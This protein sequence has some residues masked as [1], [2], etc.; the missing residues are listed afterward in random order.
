MSEK[1]TRQTGEPT[2]LAS[3]RRLLNITQADLAHTCGISRQ[4][5]SMLETGRVQPNVQVALKL[6]STL[7]TTVEALFA[8]AEDAPVELEVVCARENMPTGTRVNVAKV[9]GTWVAHPSDTPDSIGG[10]FNTADGVIVRA[11]A[12]PIA[13]CD[14]PMRELEGNIVFAGCD[15]AMHLLCDAKLDAPGHST[16]INCGSGQALQYL[17]EGLVH[18]AGLH[19]GFDDGDENLRTIKRVLPGA[20]LFVMRFSSWEQGWLLSSRVPEN[21]NGVGDMIAH[22]LRIANREPGA[23]VRRW[24]DEELARQGVDPKNVQGY[25]TCHFSHTEAVESMQADRADLM[26]GPCV[27]ASVFGL[28]FIPI[29]RVAFDLVFNKNLFDHQRMDACLKW[30]ASKRFHQELS[31]LPG[32]YVQ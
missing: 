9:G 13:S 11:G 18:V 19:Y 17:S 10:G 24:L 15:P 6:A 21:F 4:F 14:H 29:G 32:Y 3:R 8:E 27:M 12:S 25:D 16:W 23:A 30:L 22:G 2:H 20:D 5:M 26:L 7:G 1:T 28:R 31:T